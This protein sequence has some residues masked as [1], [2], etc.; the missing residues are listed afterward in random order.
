MRNLFRRGGVGRRS[1]IVI[2]AVIVASLPA[3][4]AIGGAAVT[5]PTAGTIVRDVGNV[6]IHEDT[7]GQWGSSTALLCDGSSANRSPR[8]SG[9][10][11]VIR[12]SDNMT[13][14][15]NYVTPRGLFDNLATSNSHSAFDA[16]WD[17]TTATPGLYTIKSTAVNVTRAS[18]FAQCIGTAVT[19][20]QFTV[21]YRPWQHT[22]R[23]ILSTGSVS[24]NTIGAREFSYKVKDKSSDAV[25]DGTSSMTLYELGD[26][27]SFTFP[28]DPTV[29]TTNPQSCLP[30]TV[31]QCANTGPCNARLVVVDYQPNV[32]PPNKLIGIFDLQTK[33]FVASASAKGTT[34]ILAS[35]G[36]QLDAE[37]LAVL[38]STVASLQSA[39]GVDIANLLATQVRLRM[40]GPDGNEA[41]V[42]ISLGELLTIVQ[43]PP[44]GPNGI[45]VLAPFS[46]NAGYVFHQVLG[47][48]PASDTA[49]PYTVTESQL[50]PSV[51]LPL[52]VP[53]APPLLVVE[54]GGT[55]K[56]IEG[57]YP[58]A[59][60]VPIGSHSVGASA[61]ANNLDTAPNEPSG[62][63]AWLPVLSKG[64]TVPDS[65]MDFI[66]H[67]LV[68]A[69][70]V[71][72]LGSAGN[73]KV[74]FVLGFGATIF[75]KNPLPI[76]FGNLPL[77]W[78]PQ[79]PAV[80]SLIAQINSTVSGAIADPAVQD[81]LAQVLGAVPAP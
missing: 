66:G 56:H 20:S 35:L 25:I 45:N 13:V 73:L 50:V 32:S 3:F 72:P 16:V 44:T 17:T 69:N 42:F 79:D 70:S 49:K 1:G 26:P 51:P 54:P 37:L 10:I 7:G 64:A 57:N 63:P 11:E 39:S 60:N 58:S 31:K 30:P 19:R 43:G 68:I 28:S 15:T 22:F 41:S 46:V 55:L 24:M 33:A 34:R 61:L 5:T 36:T 67:A 18:L 81:L 47:V 14:T 78:D 40:T 53:A 62:L 65:D 80:Q 12:Q 48:S 52:A 75:G 71:T 21:E 38:G 29:C 4:A 77:I 9:K 6:T 76:G 8:P 74:G 2:L 59:T 27:A 23:D